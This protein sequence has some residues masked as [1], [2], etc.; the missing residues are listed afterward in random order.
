MTFLVLVLVRTAW[1]TF[2]GAR[3]HQDVLSVVLGAISRRL[4][5][6]MQ[7]GR[8]FFF[9]KG[10][11]PLILPITAK[12]VQPCRSVRVLVCLFVARCRAKS[13]FVGRGCW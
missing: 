2:F 11:S 4:L 3:F 7:E 1:L 12:W 6:R 8:Y 9:Y 13:R 10:K 5:V